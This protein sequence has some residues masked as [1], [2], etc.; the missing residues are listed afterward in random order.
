DCYNRKSAYAKSDNSGTLYNWYTATAGTNSSSYD[1]CPK[2]W[3]LPTGGPNGEFVALDKVWGGTGI[4]RDNANTIET[5][6]GNYAANANGGFTLAGWI[7][8]SLDFIDTNGRWWSSTSDGST[9][10]YNLNLY[11]PYSGVYPQDSHG[12]YRGYSVRCVAK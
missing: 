5:F 8:S 9:N 7:D 3:R 11:P 12:R 2:G 6:T 10:A 4:N 1:I